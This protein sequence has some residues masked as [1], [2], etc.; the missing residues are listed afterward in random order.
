MTY[1]FLFPPYQNRSE[2]V[3]EETGI[4]KKTEKNSHT[5]LFSW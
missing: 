2:K 3:E 5:I 4:E 1:N